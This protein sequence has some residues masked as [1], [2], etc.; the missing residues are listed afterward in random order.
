MTGISENFTELHNTGIQD[1]YLNSVIILK[2]RL[3]QVHYIR[4][5]LLSG[6][7]VFLLEKVAEFDF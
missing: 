5:I 4:V 7:S 1:N 6:R 2:T 3:S